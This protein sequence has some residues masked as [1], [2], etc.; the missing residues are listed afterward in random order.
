MPTPKR[1]FPALVLLL[2]A[3][4]PLL[5]MGMFFVKQQMIH[6]QR[7]ERF[8][9]EL[10]QTISIAKEK[11]NWLEEGKEM[12]VEG[13]HFDVKAIKNAGDQLVCT[14][15]FDKKEDRVAEKI[16][17]LN[18]QKNISGHA[19]I[20][21]FKFLFLPAYKEVITFSIQHKWHAYAVKFPL[22]VESLANIHY[23]VKAP[24]PRFC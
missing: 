5:L 18:T 14:G 23:P 1:Q 3:A 17:D 15:F 2:V 22:Y 20:R 19:Q 9:N 12:L 13:K 11:V 24:P 7:K 8:E 16:S 4:A 6:Q 10:L 21:T